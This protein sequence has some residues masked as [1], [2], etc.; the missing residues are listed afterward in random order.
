MN[1]GKGIT[2]A[3]TLFIG[4]IVTLG[5]ILMRQNVDLVADDYY[6]QEINYETQISAESN[7]RKL[8]VLPTF[9]QDENYFIVSIPE[10]AFTKMTLDLSRPNNSDKDQHFD[11]NGTKMFMIEKSDLEKGQY[12]IA[13]RY[14]FDGKPCQQKTDVFIKK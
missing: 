4:F 2:V 12:G 14:E 6:Q 9:A 8:E 10:G 5:V 1:W 7:A 11:I 3:L 13:L